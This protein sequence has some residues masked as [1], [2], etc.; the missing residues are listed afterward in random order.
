MNI[1]KFKLNIYIIIIIYKINKN[2]YNIYKN[3]FDKKKLLLL[4]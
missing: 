4:N 2:K 3:L 1:F